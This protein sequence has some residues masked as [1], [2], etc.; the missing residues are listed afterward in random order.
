MRLVLA[1][2]ILAAGLTSASA[3]CLAVGTEAY[4][5]MSPD[6]RSFFGTAVA[7]T[8]DFV[9]VGVPFADDGPV[10]VFDVSTGANVMDFEASDEASTGGLGYTLAASGSLV[11]A[12]AP[13]ERHDGEADVGAV[14]LFDLSTG[15]RRFRLI[16]DHDLPAG[17][18]GQ[19]LAVSDRYA[20]VGGVEYLG[21][22]ELTPGAV[23]VYD[24][25]TGELLHTLTPVG[26]SENDWFGAGIAVTGDLAAVGASWD[27]AHGA[28]SGVV[29]LFDLTSGEQVGVLIPDD[30]HS[31]KYFGSSL[32]ISEMML[33]V[34]A[35]GDT[36]A[37]PDA[38]AIYVFDVSTLDQLFKL[39]PPDPTHSHLGGRVAMQGSVVV[40]SESFRDQLYV[41]ELT[42]RVPV[43]RLD[44]DDGTH[45]GNR[46]S[47]A[48]SS[49][50]IVSGAWDGDSVFVYSAPFMDV[51]DHIDL[52]VP[53]GDV[54]IQDVLTF[55]DAFS[56]SDPLADFAEPFGVLDLADID[57]LLVAY[58]ACR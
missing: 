46:L 29:Y 11:L 15:V 2:A 12:G 13:W 49:A 44:T 24:V 22:G 54:Q 3:Q 32:A 27:D 30:Q 6:G 33:A 37:G 57:T 40:G 26:G 39:M 53:C 47:V 41:F 8:E 58:H 31:E 4:S 23:W 35:T 38:G 36:E 43:M 56:D 14:H 34:A 9:I 17:V 5:L 7:A 25:A 10:R 21:D 52:A 45:G 1:M 16:A 19:S 48:I 42:N 20:L 18:F 50:G 55:I 51:C 28:Y